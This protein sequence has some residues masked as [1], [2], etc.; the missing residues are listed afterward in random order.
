METGEETPGLIRNIT[1][2]EFL[3][4]NGDEKT[5]VIGQRLADKLFIDVGD[6]IKLVDCFVGEWQ[7]EKQV[8][9]GRNGTIEKL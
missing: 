4:Q 9:T 8:T 3:L 6:K 1:K 5:I 7:G 2:G